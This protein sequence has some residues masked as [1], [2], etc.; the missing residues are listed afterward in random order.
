MQWPGLGRIAWVCCRKPLAR[1]TN[2][3]SLLVSLQTDSL[4]SKIAIFFYV[5]KTHNLLT[6]KNMIMSMF[7]P[8]LNSI[9]H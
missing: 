7:Q 8:R 1:T 2:I 9:C 3:E 5:P 4:V 6:A